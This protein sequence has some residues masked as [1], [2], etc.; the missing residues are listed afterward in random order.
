MR[1]DEVTRCQL[2]SQLF[3]SLQQS[4]VIGDKD[5]DVIANFGKFRRGPDEIWNRAR[6][7]V[8]NENRKPFPAQIPSHSATDYSKS[9]H[10][11][12]FA[13]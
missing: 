12:V 8:P 3:D 5:L 9:D 1:E 13:R 6:R 7:P 11:N 4:F 10:A 2:F